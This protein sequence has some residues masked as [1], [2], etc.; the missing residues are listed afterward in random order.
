MNRD[1]KKTLVECY[2]DFIARRPDLEHK[3][4]VVIFSLFEK[5]GTID[6]LSIPET[7]TQFLFKKFN[8]RNEKNFKMVNLVLGLMAAYCTPD[9]KGFAEFKKGLVGNETSK[10]NPMFEMIF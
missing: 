3:L 4:L 6:D 2:F 8:E 1:D 10:E 5:T 9:T 7:S